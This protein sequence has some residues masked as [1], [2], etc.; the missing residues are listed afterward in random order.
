MGDKINHQRRSEGR[1]PSSSQK[2]DRIMGSRGR[3]VD[4]GQR[5]QNDKPNTREIISAAERID[6]EK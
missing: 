3:N 2:Q 4:K 1:I 5:R 6:D